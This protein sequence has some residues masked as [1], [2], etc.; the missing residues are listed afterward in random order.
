MHP[1]AKEILT[2]A[3]NFAKYA[4]AEY[5]VKAAVAKERKES[6]GGWTLD[7]GYLNNGDGKPAGPNAS[8]CIDLTEALVRIKSIA[9]LA[10]SD[11]D[12]SVDVIKM[13]WRQFMDS[14]L[15]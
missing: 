12:E 13:H 3:M 7:N 2:K 1:E 11:K 5:K 15:S 10:K 4:K 8:R 14:F 9:S 6:T